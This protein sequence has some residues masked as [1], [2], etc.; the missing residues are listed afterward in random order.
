MSLRT[1]LF[2]FVLLFGSAVLTNILALVYLVH[3]IS[4]SLNTIENIRQRQ[5]VAVQMNSHLRDAEAALYRYQIDGEAGF[6]SQFI[7]QLNNFSNDLEEYHQL[8]TDS[9]EQEWGST[10]GLANQQ[11][12]NT[13]ND[14]ITLRDHQAKHL[15]DFLAAQSQLTALLFNDIKPN[16]SDDTAYQT[17]VTN[18]QD[19]S[20]AMLSAVTGYIAS[21]DENK[22]VQFTDAV[23]AFQQALNDFR[24]TVQSENEKQWVDEITDIFNQMQSLG[25]QLIGGRDLQQSLYANFIS[26]I[27]NAGQRT[28]V[29][30]IEPHETEKFA[31]EQQALL[32]AV[33]TAM[34]A[35]ISI[36]AI[37]SVIALLFMSYLSRQV[38]A[39]T[40]ALLQ[41]AK[42]VSEG[43]LTER[44]RVGGKDEL[45]H[46]A[47]AFN[48]MMMDLVT[49]ERRLKARLTEL[50]ALRRVS[51]QLTSA[52][53][54]QAVL[55]VIAESVL[56]LTVANEVKIYT[57]AD[58]TISVSMNRA[59][60]LP[61]S[62][63]PPN[64]IV[65][66]VASTGQMHVANWNESRPLLNDP[67]SEGAISIAGLPLKLGEQAL[68]V[69]FVASSSR[70]AFTKEDIRFL[71]L[72]ADQAAVALGNASL[73]KNLQEREERLKAL[74]GKM[75]HIQD[76][77]RHLIGLDLHDG[78]TQI[79]ISANMHLNALEAAVAKQLERQAAQELE[80]SR[81]LV[82]QAIEEA[83]RVIAELRPTVIEDF[84]LEEGLQRYVVDF[85]EI[86]HWRC[87]V[88]TQIGGLKLPSAVETAIF[89]IAQEA[90][91]NIRKHAQ[92]EKVRAELFVED[93]SLL[94][95]VQ[96]WGQ[97]F[98]ASLV[99]QGETEHLGLVSMRER[100][101]MINGVCKIESQPGKG[102]YV[103]V[104][105]PLEALPHRSKDD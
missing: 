92:T 81:L 56:N 43:D 61:L 88:A 36:A 67:F 33:N 85:C 60:I 74:I 90:L 94:L 40:T 78:L 101:R 18:M 2:I 39:R 103:E 25:S 76:E 59:Q 1:R 68:G 52:L 70:R 77:E 54:P 22:R 35:S 30:Q 31:Q 5:L 17:I 89:R 80:M 62:A 58:L 6:K 91:T 87:E 84:G 86:E 97:G 11:I 49:R 34:I 13:G 26:V 15:E 99:E 38:N 24:A 63:S 27:F 100:A 95:R 96:D 105:L 83:R 98:D 50:E 32:N 72:L 93:E 44:V 16:R 75:A 102:T 41:G 3:S 4:N 28:I 20:R 51:L 57:G 21:P 65:S 73:F 29:D 64:N 47:N 45:S 14:L 69:L 9:K 104:R 79:V 7:G 10:L 82:K 37:I 8:A 42:R 66:I 12:L 23:I 46:I 53:E 19:S 71:N 55:E 48:N